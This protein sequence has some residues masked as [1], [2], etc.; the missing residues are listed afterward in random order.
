LSNPLNVFS[1]TSVLLLRDFVKEKEAE[2]QQQQQREN[3]HLKKHSFSADDTYPLF[4][5]R[6]RV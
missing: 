1:F 2:K 3:Q 5:K 6:R 4:Q